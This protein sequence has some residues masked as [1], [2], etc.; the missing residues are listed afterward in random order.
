MAF[1]YQGKEIVT[2]IYKGKE[3]SSIVLKGH[4]MHSAANL[5]TADGFVL[6]SADGFTLNAQEI[7]GKV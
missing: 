1:R 4:E 5:I 2:W 7:N 6:V 3:V